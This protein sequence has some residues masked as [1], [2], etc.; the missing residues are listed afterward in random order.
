MKSPDG[1]KYP[2]DMRR[3]G[4]ILRAG[5][6]QGFVIMEYEDENPYEKIPLA[7]TELGKALG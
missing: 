6:Y 7:L 1:K 3:I 2:A 4:E 5:N